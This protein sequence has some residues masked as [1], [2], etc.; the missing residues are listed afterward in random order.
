MATAGICPCGGHLKDLSHEIMRQSTANQWLD[1]TRF[2]GTE[3]PITIER[4]VCMACGRDEVVA[5]HKPK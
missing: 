5:V 2:K 3:T 1:N 4:K